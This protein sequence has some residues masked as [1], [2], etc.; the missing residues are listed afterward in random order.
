MAI[1]AYAIGATK[2]YV[3]IRAE[4]PLA[5]ERLVI[6]IEQA[7]DYGLIGKDILDQASTLIS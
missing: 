1:A 5:I 6:A 3:Y 2:A 7:K 4:Y